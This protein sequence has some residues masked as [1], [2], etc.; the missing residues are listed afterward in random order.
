[1]VSLW[2]WTGRGASGVDVL[3]GTGWKRMG[4]WVGDG[5]VASVEGWGWEQM[6]SGLGGG[7]EAA[8]G[9]WGCGLPG[10]AGVLASGKATGCDRMGECTAFGSEGASALGFSL[11]SKGSGKRRSSGN[12]SR[13]AAGTGGS[14]GPCREGRQ[15]PLRSRGFHGQQH[16]HGAFSLK[17]P[18]PVPAAG[19][20][21][22][23]S[24]YENGSRR[25]LFT[26]CPS[27]SMFRTT[28]LSLDK[29]GFQGLVHL[30]YIHPIFFVHS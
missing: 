16:P 28:L 20:P 22:P 27:C 26:F 17:A 15:K 1:M 11:G 9:G 4:D 2:L 24:C 21:R 13:V 23:S 3:A 25:T 8:T 6:G 7:V 30:K 29:L 12:V 18:A 5:T 19:L 14:R 10:E